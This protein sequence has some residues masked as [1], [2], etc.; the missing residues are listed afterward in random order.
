VSVDAVQISALA[1]GQRD[2]R[3]RNDLARVRSIFAAQS[4]SVRTTLVVVPLG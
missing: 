1:Q 3:E 4:S 2:A